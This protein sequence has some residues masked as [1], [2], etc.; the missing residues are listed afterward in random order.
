M[1]QCAA[2]GRTLHRV[3]QPNVQLKTA[4][5]DNYTA[6]KQKCDESCASAKQGQAGA[7]KTSAAAVVEKQCAT[8]IV[9]PEHSEKK[10]HVTDARG[11]ECF[12]CCRGGARSL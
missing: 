8:A 10:T 12:F 5:L 6:K 7:F 1:D 2:R 11:D 4:I 3:R 9:E